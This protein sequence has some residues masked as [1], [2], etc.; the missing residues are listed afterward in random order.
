MDADTEGDARQVY[1]AECDEAGHR[2]R[3]GF[4]AV[5]L[6]EAAGEGEAAGGADYCQGK[7]CEQVGGEEGQGGGGRDS[8]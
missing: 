5:G 8:A 7:I 1:W 6:C 3:G 2:A 4:I